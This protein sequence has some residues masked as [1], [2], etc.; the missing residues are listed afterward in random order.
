MSITEYHCKGHGRG[1][2]T[3]Y[4]TIYTTLDTEMLGLGWEEGEGGKEGAGSSVSFI[5]SNTND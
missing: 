5:L 4:D 3:P 2:N 1:H